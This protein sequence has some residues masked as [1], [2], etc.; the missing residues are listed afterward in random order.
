MS[1]ILTSGSGG[2]G[3]SATWGMITGTLSDQTDLQNALNAKVTI[4]GDTL[5][6]NLTIGTNDAFSL[7]LKSNNTTALTFG[8]TQIATF[9]GVLRG[10]NG[11][12]S[13]PTF[14]FSGET[15]S[16]FYLPA[17]NTLGVAFNSYGQLLQ[18]VGAGASS[19][20][21]RSASNAVQLSIYAGGTGFNSLYLGTYSK[22]DTIRIY[23]DWMDIKGADLIWDTD[24]AAPASGGGDIGYQNSGSTFLRPRNIYAGTSINAPLGVFNV[25]NSSA[26]NA[27][28]VLQGTAT[29]TTSSDGFTMAWATAGSVNIDHRLRENGYQSWWANN[30]D[31]MRLRPNGR[32]T[33]GDVTETYGFFV[34]DETKFLVN[35]QTTDINEIIGLF[36]TTALTWTPSADTNTGAFTLCLKGAQGFNLTLTGSNDFNGGLPV[37]GVP[38]AVSAIGAFG[39]ANI[40]TSGT[41]DGAVG[42]LCAVGSQNYGSVSTALVGG[43]FAVTTN[44]DA[45]GGTPIGSVVT[46]L[47]G[48]FSIYIDA[49][50][51][52]ITNAACGKFIEPYVVSGT[53][54]ITNQTAAW[55][56]GTLSISPTTNA[57]GGNI[58]ALA[59]PTSYIRLTNNPT[60]QGIHSDTFSK[61]IVLIFSGGGVVANLNGSASANDQIICGAG[62]DLTIV[63]DGAVTLIYD[64]TTLKWRVIAATL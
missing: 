16:G 57:T 64:A 9:A 17:T 41:V 33:V 58:A 25:G 30:V 36:A 61:V 13:A 21:I 47:G 63:G 8:T 15:A 50:G 3:G 43:S 35:R 20:Y 37:S 2:G 11:S 59:V 23:Q 22:L 31:S 38:F 19:A 56:D 52:S 14:S 44:D 18:L 28:Q 46:A 42:L 24:N 49:G 39:Q 55:I 4:G 53:G 6:A 51:C 62:V 5:G 12:S 7:I 27:I 26:S 60:I 10:P 1:Q 29:G 32:F 40:A 45:G 48:N 54:V 34:N